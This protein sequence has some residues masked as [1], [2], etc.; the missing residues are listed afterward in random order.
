MSLPRSAPATASAPR[1]P[2]LSLDT[3]AVLAA[4]AFVLLI[5]AGVLPRVPW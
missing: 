4:S 5:V 3:W 1:A 2:L